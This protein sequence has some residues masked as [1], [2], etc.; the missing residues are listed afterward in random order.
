[1]V[2]PPGFGPTFSIV[3]DLVSEEVQKSR[4]ASQQ[5]KVLQEHVEIAQS[6]K[7]IDDH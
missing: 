6:P 3:H 7:F 5:S 1:M 4:N 2:R